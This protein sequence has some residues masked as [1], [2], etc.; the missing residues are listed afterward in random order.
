[1]V[2]NNISGPLRIFRYIPLC[3]LHH[4]I[5]NLHCIVSLGSLLARLVELLNDRVNKRVY[6]WHVLKVKLLHEDLLT[7]IVC[8]VHSLSL[9]ALVI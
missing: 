1:M 3:L 8:Q 4:K 5:L 2:V 7:S 6:L 9:R